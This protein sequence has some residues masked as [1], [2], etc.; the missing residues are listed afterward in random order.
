M[1]IRVAHHCEWMYYY[2]LSNCSPTPRDVRANSHFLVLNSHFDYK[3][4]LLQSLPLPLYLVVS[5]SVSQSAT[6]EDLLLLAS[7]QSC[8]CLLRQ[9]NGTTSR[10]RQQYCRCN[11][12][13]QSLA[14]DLI[15]SLGRRRAKKGKGGRGGSLGEAV[16]LR[17]VD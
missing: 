14:G 17:A 15:L 16:V 2:E 8:C 1:I 9:H 13:T 3:K 6:N 10:Q 7:T 5:Q 12:Y 4:L 11:T